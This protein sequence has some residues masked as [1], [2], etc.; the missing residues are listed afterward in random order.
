MQPAPGALARGNGDARSVAALF[1]D[2][3]SGQGRPG[4]I[5]RRDRSHARRF[6]ARARQRSPLCAVDAALYARRRSRSGC[7]VRGSG[8]ARGGAQ[9]HG[10]DRQRLTA[11]TR[12][13][14]DAPNRIGRAAFP[15][16]GRSSTGSRP[17]PWR[18]GLHCRRG[19]SVPPR[20][21]GA[22]SGPRSCPR[23]PVR[24]AG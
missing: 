21:R 23:R 13:S 4:R 2:A 24:S 1:R 5:A 19:A 7:R 16:S 9:Y 12:G 18:R 6:R 3:R 11:L 20:L 8:R 10:Y 17:T 22:R 14:G 15:V